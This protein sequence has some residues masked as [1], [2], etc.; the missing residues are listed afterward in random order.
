MVYISLKIG[1]SINVNIET[2]LFDLS[3]VF[4]CDISVTVIC[5]SLTL[6][7]KLYDG[8]CDVNLPRVEVRGRGN[9]VKP[10][11]VGVKHDVSEYC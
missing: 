5:S 3:I 2:I 9:R 8:H 1:V 10:L 4:V 6:L 7:F 11:V